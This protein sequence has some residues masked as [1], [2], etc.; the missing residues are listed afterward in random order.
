MRPFY[1]LLSEEQA[2]KY[3]E[4]KSE[5]ILA[6][7]KMSE[8]DAK[9]AREDI[10]KEIK[11][12][13]FNPEKTDNLYSVQ[14]QI[15]IIPIAGML[16]NKVDICAG[17]FGETV[18][19][20]RFIQE[21][22]AKAEKDPLIKSILFDVNSGGGN[23]SGC[24]QTFQSILSA[25]KPTT[26]AV[27]D[28]AASAAFWLASAADEIISV[29]KTGFFG[30]IGVVVEYV[31]RD[32]QDKK[33]GIKRTVI[34]NTTSDQKWPDETTKAGKEVIRD[35]L[36]AIFKVF[37]Q[38]IL[39]KRSNKLTQKS[40]E[41]L[42]GKV[43]ISEDAIK[44]GLADIQLNQDQVIN[45]I[46]S[47]IKGSED[48][49]HFAADNNTGSYDLENTTPEGDHMEETMSTSTMTMSLKQ[50]LDSNP[51]AKAAYNAAILSAKAEGV[52]SG[53]AEAQK[54]IDATVN[55]IG[56]ENYKGIEPLAKKVL[57]GESD[58]AALDGAVTAFD[59]LK[60]KGKSADAKNETDKPGETLA[61][62]HNLNTDGMI[63]S[64]A[65][66]LALQSK[67]GEK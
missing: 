25:V 10:I 6:R 31:N 59:M 48:V 39:V 16:V 63:S 52:E 38:S 4:V 35:E 64:E 45:H 21:A 56:N 11:V 42:S 26:A 49:D 44:F 46:E 27:H 13:D 34:T 3:A 19:T 18:T 7:S 36:N 67:D 41:D 28:M 40:I 55:Y 43:L 60:E 58:I 15:A 17:F 51:D 62:N 61:E 37:T 65:D 24:E 1:Y 8:V 12:N 53:K 5:I 20:Y 50:F 32:D 22:V 14:N 23:V 57:K 66:I 54:R 30:S 33:S 47:K 2:K 29:S 9:A